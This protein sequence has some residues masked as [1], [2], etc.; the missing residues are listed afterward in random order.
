MAQIFHHSVNSIAKAFIIGSTLL[1]VALC[2]LGWIV[3]R[4]PY[5]TAQGIIREQPIP[6]SHTHHVK[7]LGIDCRYCH[8]SVEES[9]FAGFPATKTC[10]T[11]HSQIYRDAPMLEPVRKSF[12]ENKPIHWNRVHNLA[13]YVYFN[14]SIHVAK[15]V[16][17]NV[18]HG[19]VDEMRLTWQHAT[20]QMDWCL[21]CHRNPE[22]FI[23]PKDEVFNL[24]YDPAK[25]A[26][27]RGVSVPSMQ[28]ELMKEYHIRAEQLTN[29]SMCHR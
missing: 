23:R 3:D 28:A 12:A 18:C 25:E 4:S 11:C 20:L 2:T 15:G 19:Q 26:A 24:Q 8:T 9:S 1:V 6:F 22:K 16:G 29:C 13:D 27:S 14:H 21:S 17:C 10:M 7:G 5:T